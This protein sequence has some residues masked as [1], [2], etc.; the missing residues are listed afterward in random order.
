MRWIS[1]QTPRQT[2]GHGRIQSHAISQPVDA[3]KSSPA[4]S[5]RSPECPRVFRAFGFWLL[6]FGFWLLALGSWLLAFECFDPGL[7][8]FHDFDG[9]DPQVKLVDIEKW[10]YLQ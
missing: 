2:M 10:P 6:A 3:R 1:G 4:T 5:S 8:H 9:P 7:R